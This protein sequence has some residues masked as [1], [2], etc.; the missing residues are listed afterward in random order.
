MWGNKR[1]ERARLTTWSE[2]GLLSP[3]LPSEAMRLPPPAAVPVVPTN[4]G[5]VR[6][7][8][9]S[10]GARTSRLPSAHPA[11]VLGRC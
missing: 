4:T 9:N 7:T 8:R 2:R 6:H 3:L 1:P 10:G 11:D 5:G